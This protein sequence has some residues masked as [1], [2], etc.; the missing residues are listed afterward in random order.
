MR[1]SFE[2]GGREGRRRGKAIF[3][4][5]ERQK[6]HGRTVEENDPPHQTL[7]LSDTQKCLALSSKLTLLFVS[8]LMQD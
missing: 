1:L 4:Q 8:D 2:R 5:R 7:V 6:G 3:P